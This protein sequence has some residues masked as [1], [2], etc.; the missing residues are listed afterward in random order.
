MFCM[1]KVMLI[2]YATG[3]TLQQLSFSWVGDW[4]ASNRS[5]EIKRQCSRV[6]HYL[7]ILM[8]RA[9]NQLQPTPVARWTERF[10]YAS[11]Q[12]RPRTGLPGTQPGVGN[13]RNAKR[14]NG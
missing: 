10:C 14:E 12:F 1:S 5:I 8:P 9:M 11:W 4:L 3:K 13:L 7:M 2:R 6:M